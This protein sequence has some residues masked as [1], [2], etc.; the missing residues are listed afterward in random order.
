MKKVACVYSIANISSNKI[1]IGSTVNYKKRIQKHLSLLRRDKHINKQLQ[2]D[3]NKYGEDNFIF[4]I[5]LEVDDLDDLRDLEKHYI[6]IYC[7]EDDYNSK[8]DSYAPLTFKL[9]DQSWVVGI[10]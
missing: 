5:L 6:D 10:H 1:Y 7:T 9:S 8:Y 2:E 3:F 4:D